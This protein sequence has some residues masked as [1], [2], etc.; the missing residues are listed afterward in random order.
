MVC[1]HNRLYLI[2]AMRVY[3]NKKCVYSHSVDGSRFYIGKG[4]IH[5]PY[6]PRGRNKIWKEIVSASGY[7]DVDIL[8]WVDTDKEAKI[9]EAELIAEFKPIANIHGI[10]HAPSVD[11]SDRFPHLPK[12]CPIRKTL[13]KKSVID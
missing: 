13:S 6:D 2:I 9:R 1:G 8:T 12:R 11:S 7:F 5:R 10:S 3:L 4:D